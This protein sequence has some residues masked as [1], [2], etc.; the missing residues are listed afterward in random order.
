MTA[1]A[2]LSAIPSTNA[3]R[4]YPLLAITYD[5]GQPRTNAGACVTSWACPPVRR[6]RTGR[7]SASVAIWMFVVNPP[8]ER[9]NA[10]CLCP[11]SRRRLLMRADDRR[12]DHQILVLRVLHQ[13]G[14]YALPH[15]RLG[16]PGQS[17]MRTLPVAVALW[18]VLPVRRAPQHPHDAIRERAIIRRRTASIASFPGQHPLNPAPLRRCQFVSTGHRSLLDLQ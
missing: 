12:V 2:P 11:P 1:M 17:L 10:S 4:S 18:Q 9:P 6:K 3:W 15:P 7:P 16:P 8:R 14:K 13:H 5:S